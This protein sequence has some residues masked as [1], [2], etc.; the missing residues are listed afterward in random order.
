[1]ILENINIELR[2]KLQLQQ[3]K[4]TTAPINWFKIIEN[5]KKYEYMNF[6]IKDFFS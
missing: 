1:M 4:N 2:N 6:D 5:K 3:L